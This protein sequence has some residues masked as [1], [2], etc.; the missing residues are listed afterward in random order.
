[1]KQTAFA[2]V[3]VSPGSVLREEIGTRLGISQ[4]RLARAIGVSRLTINEIVNEKRAVT[5]EMALKLSK[6][7]G[8]DP[9]FWLTL[10]L[11]L[12]LARAR[13]KCGELPEVEVLRPRV[14]FPGI[15]SLRE[16][17]LAAG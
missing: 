2:P 12:D 15:E 14:E 9:E 8:T 7:L 5:A 17:R 4:D 10:Q 13:E 1:M 3:A 6:A 16:R 11:G